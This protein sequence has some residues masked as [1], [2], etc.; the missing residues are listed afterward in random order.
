MQ[1]SF[2]REVLRGYQDILF[3]YLNVNKRRFV[4]TERQNPNN[5][6][7]K[8]DSLYKKLQEHIMFEW[9]QFLM[10]LLIIHN[11]IKPASWT[12]GTDISFCY[13]IICLGSSHEKVVVELIINFNY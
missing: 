1:K 2:T 3:D 13:Y 12:F 7:L 6:L 5:N 10:N 8:H 9:K 4:C 11:V